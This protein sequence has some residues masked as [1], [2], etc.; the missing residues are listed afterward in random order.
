MLTG[1]KNMHDIPRVSHQGTEEYGSK[2]DVLVCLMNRRGTRIL[3]KTFSYAGTSK[4]ILVILDGENKESIKS[5]FEKYNRYTF[6][7][8]DREAIY[9]QLVKCIDE[10]VPIR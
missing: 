7:D 3:G 9:A 2:V 6:V 8:N 4:E 10:G 1:T 5:H